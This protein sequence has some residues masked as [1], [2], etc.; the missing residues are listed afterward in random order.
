M[1]DEYTPSTEQVRIAYT[2]IGEDAPAIAEQR[3]AAFDRWLASVKAEAWD[4][5]V[6]QL[7]DALQTPPDGLTQGEY[8]KCVIA[9]LIAQGSPYRQGVQ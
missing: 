5:A 3:R 4:E 7:G 2:F 1:T 9:T 6:Q 8:R